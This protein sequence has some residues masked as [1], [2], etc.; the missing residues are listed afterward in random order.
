MS[1]LSDFSKLLKPTKLALSLSGGGAKSLIYLGA[2]KA[3]EENGIKIEYIGGLSGGAIIAGM[4]G[5]GMSTDEIFKM[6]MDV[7]FSGLLDFNPLDGFELLEHHKVEALLRQYLGDKKIEELK[8]PVIIFTTNI[9]SKKAELL[10]TG[11]LVSAIMA[12]CALPP[13]MA[14]I[15]R[16]GKTLMEG[17]FA[18]H[19]GA[20]YFRELGATKVIGLDVNGFANT[21]L[22]GI[23]GNFYSGIS[24]ALDALAIYEQKEDPVDFEINEFDDSTGMFEF[25]KMGEEV[26]RVGNDTMKKHISEVR[27]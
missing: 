6:A 16:E 22:P 18:T 15:E 10:K 2:I 1:V 9:E 23:I 12:S 3:L 5:A 7:K 13:L 11:D 14:P 21:K 8:L 27:F 19:Y 4:Y 26:M 20:K 17:G 24:A 25:K